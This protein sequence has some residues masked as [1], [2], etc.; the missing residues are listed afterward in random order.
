MESNGIDKLTK[1]LMTN[2]RLNLINPEFD[3]SVMNQILSESNRQESRKHFLV[4]IVIFGSIELVIF[5]ILF[6]LLNYFPVAESLNSTMKNSM[7]IFQKIGEF[8]IHY[9]YLILSFIVVAFLDLIMTKRGTTSMKP[10][11]RAN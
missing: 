5:T 10:D 6:I 1:E 11:F 4:N 8:A 7:Y 3:K 2:S 9:D